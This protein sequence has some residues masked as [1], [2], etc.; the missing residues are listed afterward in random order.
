[1]CLGAGGEAGVM[2]ELPLDRVL[3]SETPLHVAGPSS[4]ASPSCNLR[5]NLQD[6]HSYF[7]MYEQASPAGLHIISRCSRNVIY[8]SC[9]IDAMRT[10]TY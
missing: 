3:D 8:F 6:V 5:S 9:C 7:H 2:E 4:P 10:S 1:M